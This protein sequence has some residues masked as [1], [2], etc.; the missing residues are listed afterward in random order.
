MQCEIIQRGI[1]HDEA[2]NCTRTTTTTNDNLTNNDI[3]ILND[4]SNST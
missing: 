1:W 2:T 3:D 4:I